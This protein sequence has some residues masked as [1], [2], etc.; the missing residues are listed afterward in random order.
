MT[1]TTHSRAEADCVARELR[2]FGSEVAENPRGWQVAVAA[3][4]DVVP[5]MDALEKC[6]AEN[7]IASVAVSIQDRTYVMEAASGSG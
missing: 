1:I 4:E 2:A 6:L 5:I 3:D 7:G